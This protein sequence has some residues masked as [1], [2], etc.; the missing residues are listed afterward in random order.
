MAPPSVPPPLSAGSVARAAA[1]SIGA[2]SDPALLSWRGEVEVEQER[3]RSWRVEL[4]ESSL[5]F[6]DILAAR[7]R[8]LPAQ[9]GGRPVREVEVVLHHPAHMAAPHFAPLTLLTVSFPKA[10]CCLDSHLLLNFGGS[11]FS[12]S[13][14][15]A[16]FVSKYLDLGHSTS[17]C[18]VPWTYVRC[19]KA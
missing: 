3:R 1:R 15:C 17:A 14:T 13:A 16:P 4:E 12:C 8:M 9:V 5:S 18:L 19:S 11:C 6:L 10:G 7:D 2:H